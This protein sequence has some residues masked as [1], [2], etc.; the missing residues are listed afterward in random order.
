M[1]FWIVC[2]IATT[3]IANEKGLNALSYFFLGLLLGPLAVLIV[4]LVTSKKKKNGH[5]GGIFDIKTAKHQLEDIKDDL[6]LLKSRAK[7]LEERIGTLEQNEPAVAPDNVLKRD[8]KPEFAVDQE[9]QRFTKPDNQ[10]SLEVVFGKVWLNRIGVVLFVLGIGYF[11]SY[12]FQYLGVYAKIGLGYL[13]SG[14]FFLFGKLLERNPKFTKI[15]WGIIAGGWGLAYLTTYAVHY[16]PA[17]QIITNSF[18]AILLLS[19]VSGASIIYNLKYKSC[20]VTS[21][22]YL[23]AF[24]TVIL[25][26]IQYSTIAYVAI[27]V[28]SLCLLALRLN[29]PILIYFGLAASYFTEM[30]ISNSSHFVPFGYK[31]LQS[32]G[33]PDY[34]YIEFSILFVS[35]L[36]FS[37]TLL[38]FKKIE[39]EEYP[40]QVSA[41]LMNAGAFTVLG[42]LA[43]DLGSERLNLPFDEKFW[44]FMAL[45]GCYLLMAYLYKRL[46]QGKLIVVNVTIAMAL[47]SLAILNKAPSASLS[48][49]WLLQAAGL[50]NLGVYYKERI[51]R[52]AAT[53]L[54][55]ML[56]VRIL[57][58]DL[59]SRLTIDFLGVDV[60]LSVWI[61]AVTA[62]CF[63]LF[64]YICQKVKDKDNSIIEEM[65]FYEMIYPISA[66]I[67][68]VILIENELAVRWLSLSWALLGAMILSAGFCFQNKILRINA[69]CVLS[70]ACLRVVFIDMRHVNTIYKIIAFIA[71][72]AIMMGISMFYS[73]Y[74]DKNSK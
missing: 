50:F 19:I 43:I 11:I 65:K 3:V 45:S 25:G 29:W 20:I 54:S 2:I 60:K 53:G 21:L 55:S 37:I 70:L 8:E 42:L 61:A 28:G 41:G 47:L 27:L 16:F 44:F 51:Y 64:G 39:N 32:M 7:A 33:S 17:T 9:K 52:M 71:L 12:T 46:N 67:L 14:T 57:Y 5:V 34:F 72:G 4:L 59:S 58:I 30:S 48:F 23:L 26:G 63:Y 69:L 40:F 18:T 24:L 73:G 35:W 22:T 62:L 74:K 1:L 66:T 15:A 49:Y 36:A 13:L 6:F 38:L 68:A 31:P 56:M 10:E